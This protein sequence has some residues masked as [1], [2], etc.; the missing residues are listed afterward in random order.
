MG[1][2]CQSTPVRINRASASFKPD[3]P[4][5]SDMWS[6]KGALTAYWEAEEAQLDNGATHNVT[7]D[8]SWLS[9]FK[10]LPN[11]IPLSVATKAPPAYLTGIRTMML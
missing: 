8:V 10:P 5:P 2:N 3:G 6:S 9:D 4:L 7:N 11:P 1:S